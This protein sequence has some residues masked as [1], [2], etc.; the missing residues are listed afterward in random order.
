MS[1]STF[2]D[3]AALGSGWTSPASD[4]DI[5]QNALRKAKIIKCAVAHR[6]LAHQTES[7]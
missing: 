4:G 1:L 2:D 7:V 5:V 3:P 6:V